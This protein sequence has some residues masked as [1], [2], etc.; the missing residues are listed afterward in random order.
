MQEDRKKQP[1][2]VG[3]ELMNTILGILEDCGVIEIEHVVVDEERGIVDEIIRPK[4]VFN[5]DLFSESELKVIRQVMCEL[6]DKTDAELS[7]MLMNEA[8][9]SDLEV[10]EEVP[11]ERAKDL[12]MA[13][14]G[15]KG[16][17]K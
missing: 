15:D 9:L 1:R 13:S 2:G 17:R 14:N 6:G 8:T 10:R 5:P 11:Y 16:G 12:K 3:L 4:I 7:E